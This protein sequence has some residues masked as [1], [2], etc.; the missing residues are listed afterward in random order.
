MF[1]LARQLELVSNISKIDVKAYGPNW[2]L[3]RLLNDKYREFVNGHGGWYYRWL[4][5]AVRA[6][7]PK[8]IL[9]LGPYKGVSTLMMYNELPAMSKLTTVDLLKDQEFIPHEVY[10]DSRFRLVIGDD[11][12]LSIYDDN[13]PSNVD[14][15]FIDTEHFYSQIMKEWDLYRDFL[16]EGA[17]VVLDDIRLNDMPRFWDMLRYPKEDLTSLCHPSGFGVF[18]YRRGVEQPNISAS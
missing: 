6:I 13:L 1:L 17:L 18:E 11:L 3:L 14:F 4:A 8:H 16:L 15:L 2:D 9:E 12:D 7:G 5:L 10:G